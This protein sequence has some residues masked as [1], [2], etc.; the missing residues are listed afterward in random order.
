MAFPCSFAG[1]L[2][3]S[4]SWTLLEMPINMKGIV[5]L[6]DLSS[7][8]DNQII[9][10]CIANHR[11]SKLTVNEC[12][13][14][15][16]F[17][18]HEMIAHR[19]EE[20]SEENVLTTSEKASLNRFRNTVASVLQLPQNWSNDDLNNRTGWRSGS[21]E[22]P[23]DHCLGVWSSLPRHTEVVYVVGQFLAID[24][25]FLLRDVL[26]CIP[27]V[28][29][30]ITDNNDREKLSAIL[31]D[32]RLKEVTARAHNVSTSATVGSC[33]PSPQHPVVLVRNLNRWGCPENSNE[34]DPIGKVLMPMFDKWNPVIFIHLSEVILR[35]LEA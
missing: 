8:I 31:N 11:A 32:A 13:K 22:D 26:G 7:K 20:R 34:P 15:I 27:Q 10:L 17:E 23:L 30:C 2:T 29:F 25:D 19:C 33:E 18:L 21:S 12:L 14:E 28:R 9:S 24:R 5:N 6:N 4:L 35:I 16:T 1:I 3:L